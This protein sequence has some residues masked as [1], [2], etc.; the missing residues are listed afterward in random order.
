MKM[1][2]CVI[3]MLALGGAVVGCSGG[4]GPATPPFD[5]FGNDP[6]NASLDP[7]GGSNEMPPSSGGGQTIAQLCSTDCARVAAACPTTASS[8]CVSSC[9]AEPQTYPACVPQVQAFLECYATATITCSTTS[10]TSASGCTAV[11]QALVS[12]INPGAT[13]S[14]GGTYY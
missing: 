1:R 10:G 5:P 3:A 12:C 13:V 4:G 14:T 8:N 6:S 11:E 7:A 2:L 9:D